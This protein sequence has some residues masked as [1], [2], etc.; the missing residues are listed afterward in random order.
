MGDWD[1]VFDETYLLTYLPF[2]DDERTRAE[3]LGAAKLAGLEQGAEILDCPCGFGRHSLVLTE[4]GY[5]VTGL[6]RS[7]TL[8]AEAERRRGEREWPR[9]VRGDYRELLFADA[10]SVMWWGVDH[11]TKNRLKVEWVVEAAAGSRVG[12]VARHDRA[13]TVRAET[14]M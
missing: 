8:L 14:T 7:E 11:S 13:G 2:V 5:E 10:S 9:L 12:V 6:D 1:A 4:A 3:A